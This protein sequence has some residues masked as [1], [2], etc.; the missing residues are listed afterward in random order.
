MSKS[1]IC[2]V[3]EKD[4]DFVP[5]VKFVF[6]GEDYAICSEH[7]PILIHKPHE[8]AEKLP[9]AEDIPSGDHAD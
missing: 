4:S 1:K 6:K 9:Q 3:C 2:L 7:L 5:L 8:L